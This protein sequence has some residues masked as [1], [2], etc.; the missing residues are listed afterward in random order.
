MKKTVWPLLS[1]PLEIDVAQEWEIV[2]KVFA[3]RLR[4]MFTLNLLKRSS[5]DI[6][7]G[8]VVLRL[9]IVGLRN[10]NLT[11]VPAMPARLL[12]AFQLST[13]RV[14]T[15]VRYHMARRFIPAQSPELLP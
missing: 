12:K 11:T 6:F 8:I 2:M 14:F 7:Q 9:L 13:F 10:V 1:P 15:M 5:V 3:V 4:V